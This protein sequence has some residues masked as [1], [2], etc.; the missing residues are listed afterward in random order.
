MRRRIG[1]LASEQGW[2]DTPLDSRALN[3]CKAH[4][5][6]M[7]MPNVI[8][9]THNYFQA[10]AADQDGIGLIPFEAGFGLENASQYPTYQAYVSTGPQYWSQRS[11]HY[12]CQ[13]AQ[14]GCPGS[15]PS[16]PSTPAPSGP[17]PPAPAPS[18]GHDVVGIIDGIETSGGT[19][20]L[21]GWACDVGSLTS[22]NID[23]YANGQAG[24]GTGI[25][26]FVANLPS[27]PAVA[28]V[29][30]TN[31]SAYRFKNRP[32]ALPRRLPECAALRPR[33][34]NQ[35]WCQ[36]FAD[37]LRPIHHA[38]PVSMQLRMKS[39]PPH[40]MAARSFSLSTGVKRR[41][42]ARAA[43]LGTLPRPGQG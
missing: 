29:C 23:L 24:V 10:D 31:G 34:F 9:T 21:G 11:D 20:V 30:Q 6:I 27:E 28:A 18:T 5:I 25:G 40:D 3:M 42:Y 1:W 14:L 16:Q 35:R 19:T 13:Q 43:R 15:L 32:R 12:C 37:A 41:S 33:H 39:K 38:K 26:R 4:N 7:A 17:T 8:G 2:F 22:I 36:Q